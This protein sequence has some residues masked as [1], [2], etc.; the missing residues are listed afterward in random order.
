MHWSLELAAP[1][2]KGDS[3]NRSAFTEAGKEYQ[4]QSKACN[5]VPKYI[6]GEHFVSVAATNRIILPD[7]PA[8]SKVRHVWVWERRPRPYVPVWSFAKIPR[9]NISPQ[10]NA[11]LLSIY[12]RPW[13]LNPADATKMVPLLTDLGRPNVIKK[14]TDSADIMAVTSTDNA[15]RRRLRCKSASSTQRSYA[16][17]WQQYID[18]NV[19]S[20]LNRRYIVNMLAATAARVTEKTDD[21]DSESDEHDLEGWKTHA[22]NMRIINDTLKGIAAHDED[23]GRIALGRYATTIKLGRDLGESRPLTAHERK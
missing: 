19:V 5:T 8:L 4:K 12:M 2:A 1:P 21:S 23:E 3:G 10:E 20:N 14:A 22:G 18:G 7:L 15:K 17:S 11:R 16:L 13:T 9:A 6:A